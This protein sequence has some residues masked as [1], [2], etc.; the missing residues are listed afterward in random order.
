MQERTCSGKA[1]PG[2]F[3]RF[4]NVKTPGHHERNE[5]TGGSSPFTLLRT[6]FEVFS[7]AA[8]RTDRTNRG[9]SMAARAVRFVTARRGVRR[10]PH[11]GRRP[12]AP[13]VRNAR[14]RL[15]LG[16]VF[17]RQRC[18]QAGSG[19]RAAECGRPE[20]TREGGDGADRMGAGGVGPAADALH[21]MPPLPNRRGG[22]GAAEHQKRNLMPISAMMLPAADSMPAL[23]MA[24]PPSFFFHE[25]PTEWAPPSID[26]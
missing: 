5:S 26:A 4:G 16:M 14:W 8:T 10:S 20:T 7:T 3:R 25:M 12:F 13:H 11:A 9:R 21:D 24:P 19:G 1:Q 18:R 17:R 22:A 23:S 2:A 15:P 6:G